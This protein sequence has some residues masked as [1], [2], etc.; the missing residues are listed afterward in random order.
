MDR[1]TFIPL[2]LNYVANKASRGASKVY[3]D[4]FGIG[5]NEWR[6]LSILAHDDTSTANVITELI[7]LDGAAAS[8][9]IAS[10]ERAGYLR[11]LVDANDGRRLILKLTPKGAA[12]HGQVLAVALKLQERLIRGL[13]EEEVTVL[14]R[15]LTLLR[16][17][18]ATIS[19][20][21]YAALVPAAPRKGPKVSSGD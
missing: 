19:E 8:R 1:T 14:R 20:F 6:I 2:L 10:L 17:N 18:A 12:L 4:L 7:D 16:S 9:N 13:S 15:L 11:R 21:D 3:L 5:I